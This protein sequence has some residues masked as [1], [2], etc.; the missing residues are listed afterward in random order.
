MWIRS[1]RVVKTGINAGWPAF[2]IAEE[3]QVADRSVPAARHFAADATPGR[4]RAM[5]RSRCAR[6]LKQASMCG[7][8]RSASLPSYRRVWLGQADAGEW[9]LTHTASRLN[10]AHG[11]R[12]PPHD[13][14]YRTARRKVVHVDQSPVV[15]RRAESATYTG[16]WDQIRKLFAV[17]EAKS[18]YGPTLSPSQRQRRRC[19]SC[20]GYLAR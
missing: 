16:V 14:K 7:R 17:T 1:R 5:S 3:P 8:S 9:P 20:K 2:R 11:A 4:R 6:N 15:V 12:P 10:G 18:G 13:H 19:E